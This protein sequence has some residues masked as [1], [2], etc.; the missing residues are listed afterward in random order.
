MCLE[1]ISVKVW[2]EGR[3]ILIFVL[4]LIYFL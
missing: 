3:V 2:F 1:Y 4:E